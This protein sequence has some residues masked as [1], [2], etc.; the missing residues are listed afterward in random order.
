M[1]AAGLVV[2]LA[3]VAGAMPG[4]V[5]WEIRDD[6]RTT[7][8]KLVQVQ[9]DL[10]RANK[11]LDSAN[12]AIATANTNLDKVETGLKRLDQTNTLIDGV[13][14]G[15]GRIDRTN[16]S[17]TDLEKQLALLESIEKSLG[18]LDAHLAAVRQTI[19]SINKMVPFL[20]L[21]GGYEEPPVDGGTTAA[22]E[23]KAESASAELTDKSAAAGES[24]PAKRDSLVGIWVRK[25]P[26]V[27]VALVVMSD[28][29]YVRSDLPSTPGTL[30]AT[31]QSGRWKR[32]GSVVTF[33][34]VAAPT[35]EQAQQAAT[36]EN[37]RSAPAAT[38]APKLADPEWTAT[39]V[40]AGNK[41][42][43]LQVGTELWVFERP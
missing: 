10:D 9:S 18:R 12:T 22:A 23:S 29:R 21:G 34:P 13:G 32:S 17:L 27:Q 26:N 25:Y 42:F 24:T 30:G 4:C 6:L 40:S 16:L 11:G 7:N 31:V 3:A 41:T 2:V 15:L 28:G 39:V 33:T 38:P 14:Q 36:Q 43:A 37:V 8:G 35:V 19:S 20:D 1:K 5:F